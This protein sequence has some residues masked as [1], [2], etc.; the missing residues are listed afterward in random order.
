[1]WRA[2]LRQRLLFIGALL[3]VCAVA[4]FACSANYAVFFREHKTIRYALSPASPVVSFGRLLS[5]KEKRD[6]HAPLIDPAGNVQRIGA[7]HDKPLVLFLVVGETGGAPNFQ[8]GG[9]APPTNPE[10][11][12]RQDLVYFDRATSCGTSTA[13]SVPCMFSHLPR[14]HFDVE[15]ADRYT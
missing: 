2:Q 15:Q 11:T 4:L 1:P 13:I 3:A 5:A 8:P 10:L 14:E 6:P 9:Y 7:V 12:G